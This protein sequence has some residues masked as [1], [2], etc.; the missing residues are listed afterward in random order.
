MGQ[1]SKLI[2]LMIINLKLII[3]ILSNRYAL[4]LQH[5]KNLAKSNY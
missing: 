4:P 5:K 3:F 1:T 2:F